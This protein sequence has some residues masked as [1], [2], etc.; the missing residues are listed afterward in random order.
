[1][2]NLLPYRH[3]ELAYGDDALL[4]RRDLAVKIAQVMNCW[5]D[6]EHQLALG[7][8]CLL[9]GGDRGAFAIY[10]ALIE[11]GIRETVFLALVQEKLPNTLFKKFEEFFKQVQKTASARN[12][13]VHGRWAVL[14]TRPESL[15]LCPKDFRMGQAHDLAHSVMEFLR[16][17][18]EASKVGQRK[19]KGRLSRLTSSFRRIQ[20]PPMPAFKMPDFRVPVGTRFMEYKEKE[21]DEIMNRI[22]SLSGIFWSLITES[23]TSLLGISIGHGSQ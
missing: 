1:M 2:P 16:E 11:R 19:P 20:S 3:G 6:F 22:G 13:I 15:L 8:V 18:V 17:I 9:M 21:F 12:D 23:Q 14:S 7:F 5:S 10:N 4:A